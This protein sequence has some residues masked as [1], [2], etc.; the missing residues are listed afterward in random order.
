MSTPKKPAKKKKKAPKLPK[1][2][3]DLIPKGT[4][5][6]TRDLLISLEEDEVRD[7]LAGGR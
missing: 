2:L 7:R 5:S 4:N 6:H 1:W 3:L